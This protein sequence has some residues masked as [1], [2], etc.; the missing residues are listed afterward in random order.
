MKFERSKLNLK[1]NDQDGNPIEIAAEI[2][3]KVIETT[4]ALFQVDDYE[5]FLHVPSE[6]AVRILATS[7]P[8]NS[9]GEGMSLQLSVLEVAH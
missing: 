4:E 9:H 2:E 7:Y 8:Y 6:S 3:W 1:V 5:Q